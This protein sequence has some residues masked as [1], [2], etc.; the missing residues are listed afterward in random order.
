MKAIRFEKTGGPEVLQL[1]DIDTP[2]PG[3]GQILVRHTFIGVNFIDTN[4]RGGVYPIPLPNGLGSEAAGIVDA[5]GPDVKNFAVGDR[6]VYCG[7]G[8]GAYAEAH[9]VSTS[10]AI[11]LPAGIADDI[12]A[13]ALLKGMTVQY[14]LKQTYPVKRGE[15][16]LFH[17]AAGGVG[18][19]AVQWAKHLG[20]KVIATVGS[21]EKIA[22][23]KEHGADH[24]I[25]MRKDDWVKRVQE[26]GRVPVVYDSIGK[27]SYMGSI[28]CLLVRGMLVIFGNASG[29][30]PA[31]EPQLL[32]V[33]GGLYLTRPSLAHYSRDAKEFS[34]V[35]G[36]LFAVIQ[37]GAVKITPPKRYALKDAREAHAALASR[38]TTGSMVLVP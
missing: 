35:A 6:V 29:M 10:R 30:V 7:G 27:D 13:A 2:R 33:K 38:N 22:L 1:V 12:A 8:L 28:D 34:E 23:V 18:L 31:I 5:V 16:I 19:I 17:A 32:N 25:N 26:I 14:L 4:H 37:S 9:V 21:D 20:A 36:D 24:V 3:A 11:K 15:T